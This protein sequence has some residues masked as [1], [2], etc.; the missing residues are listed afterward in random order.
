MRFEP[1]NTKC[2]IADDVINDQY[3]FNNW[4][5]TFWRHWNSDEIKSE[6]FVYL[7]TNWSTSLKCKFV[8]TQIL[9]IKSLHYF[10]NWFVLTYEPKRSCGF[11]FTTWEKTFS[12]HRRTIINVLFQLCRNKRFHVLLKF[13]ERTKHLC[14]LATPPLASVSFCDSLVTFIISVNQNIL[15]EDLIFVKVE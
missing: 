1:L 9:K 3:Y 14:L 10:I 4:Y 13:R 11:K 7:E 15:D 5:D 2:L 12:F 8:S 6:R